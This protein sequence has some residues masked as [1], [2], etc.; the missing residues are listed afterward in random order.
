VTH[1]ETIETSLQRDVFAFPRFELLILGALG[2][3]GLAFVIIGVFSVMAYAVSLQTHEIGS[4]MAI[5]AQRGDIFRMVLRKGLSL[6]TA[7]ILIGLGASVALTRLIESQLW[8]VATDPWTFAAVVLVVATVGAGA[9]FLPA[10]RATH[11]DP[12]IALR[13]E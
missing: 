12:L 7:G 4:R 1:A 5:G 10:R 13:Y 3:I 11:F 8:G 2:A 9:Y 6:V